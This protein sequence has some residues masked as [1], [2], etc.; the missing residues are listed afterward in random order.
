MTTAFNLLHKVLA[1]EVRPRVLVWGLLNTVNRNFGTG[2][3]RF[4][5]ERL[6]L[7]HPD[8]WNY[9]TTE[10]EHEKYRRTLDLVLKWRRGAASVL[11]VGCS[12]GVFSRMLAAH[13]TR[14]VGVDF[15]CEALEAAIAYNKDTKNIRFVAADMR[16]ADIGMPFDVIV[17]AE[18][19]Y[20]IAARD[21]EKVR[22]N[23]DRHLAADG[24]IAYAT[25]L[26]PRELRSP[27]A[28]AW[29][30]RLSRFLDIV[31]DEIVEDASRP[32]QLIIFAR[33]R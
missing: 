31:H 3:R 14:V 28:D 19:L 17:C 12:I 25:G 15:S 23:L 33:R 27:T 11:E 29:I 21:A 13:F 22:R 32:Y 8:P 30:G 10:Y 9:R 24:I 4:E 2:N 7:E 20:Y 18:V 6:Y 5:F 16:A 1:G 26:P